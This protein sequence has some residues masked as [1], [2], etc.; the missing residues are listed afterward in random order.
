MKLGVLFSGG[1]D[2]VFACWRAMEKN[3]VACLITLVS[4][5][6]DSYMFHTPNISRT[7]MQAEA[8]NIPLLTWKTHGIK[9]EELSD[10]R[11][12]IAA[13]KKQF[14]IQGIVTGAI[15]SVYQAARVQRVCRGLD[16]WCYNPL[17]QTDQVDYLRRLLREGFSV[18]ISGVF[19]YP[20][21]SSW[22]GAYLTEERIQ[23]LERLERR[24]RINPSGEGGEIETFVLDAPFFR[25][26]IEILVASK[27]YANYRGRFVIEK[28]RL[29]D[30]PPSPL[31]PVC[32]DNADGHSGNAGM[33]DNAGQPGNAGAF[34]QKIEPCNGHGNGESNELNKGRILLIDLCCEKDSLSNYEFVLPISDALRRAGAY[35]EI[36]H[37]AEVEP[38]DRLSCDRIVLCGTALMDNDYAEH[39]QYFSWIR[40]CKKPVLGICAGMQVIGVVYGGSI[41]QD[42]AIGLKDIEIVRSSP[43]LGEPRRIEGYHL[44]NYAVTLPQEFSLLA[45]RVDAVGA[46]QR[47]SDPVYGLIFHPE[48][49]NRW[50]LERFAA[51]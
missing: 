37:Y 21:D 28:M 40:G 1:K 19:A 23:T 9:E 43:L 35:C 31:C 14:G 3:E 50:I 7:G 29:A 15:E 11:A 38:R 49:R 22:L 42:P 44:H 51:L 33:P 48:V 47:G 16:L 18:I 26:R 12:A 10:L 34:S 46:F 36:R 24:Y 8:M 4:E 32:A 41:V 45:G 17:W 6:P 27:G 39:L 20:F 13:A 30:K 2:S 25:K 5:N